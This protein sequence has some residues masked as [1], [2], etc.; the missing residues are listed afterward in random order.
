M[1]GAPLDFI[2]YNQAHFYLFKC[3]AA[4]H[5]WNFTAVSIA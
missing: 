4:H 1:D 2:A 5:L 3:I